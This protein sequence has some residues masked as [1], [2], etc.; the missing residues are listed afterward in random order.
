MRRASTSARSFRA[1]RPLPLVFLAALVASAVVAG[2]A[3]SATS[4]PGTSPSPA[5]ASSSA[6]ARQ[7]PGSSTSAAGSV[8][9][10]GSVEPPPASGSEPPTA[11]AAGG[12]PAGIAAQDACT[13]LSTEDVAVATGL[14]DLVPTD[15]ADILDL[16]SQPGVDASVCAWH[17]E[18]GPGVTKVTHNPQLWLLTPGTLDAFQ[19]QSLWVPLTDLGVTAGTYGKAQSWALVGDTAIQV[20]GAPTLDQD[21]AL[22]RLVVRR[23]GAVG[24]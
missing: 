15:P 12:Q 14:D 5:D 22:L 13:L 7:A 8:G 21:V 17:E 19:H 3:G 11:S 9:G 18:P 6:A 23:T 16:I 24:G 4:P 20:G 10:V 2:C 1:G